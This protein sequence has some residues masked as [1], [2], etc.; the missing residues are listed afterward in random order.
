MRRG[1]MAGVSLTL[2]RLQRRRGGMAGVSLTLLRLQVAG[3]AAG[4]RCRAGQLRKE[5]K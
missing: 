2:L 1:G 3:G 4:S 5:D